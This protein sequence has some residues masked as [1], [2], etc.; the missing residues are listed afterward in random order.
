MTTMGVSLTGWQ[1]DK[2]KDHPNRMTHVKR[3]CLF[4]GKNPFTIQF[5]G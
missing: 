3:Q 1:A 4:K 2:Q 5:N